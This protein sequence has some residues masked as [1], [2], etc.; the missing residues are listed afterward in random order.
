[1][2]RS[3]MSLCP[4]DSSFLAHEQLEMVGPPMINS[5]FL[6]DDKTAGDGLKCGPLEQPVGRPVACANV[7]SFPY[8]S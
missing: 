5:W 4:F 8:A 6:V 1:M 7:T 2:D 3:G